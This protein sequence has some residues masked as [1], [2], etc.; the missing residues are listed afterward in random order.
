MS[1]TLRHRVKD[2]IVILAVRIG[3]SRPG[4]VYCLSLRIGSPFSFHR[5]LVTH[6]LTT[7]VP[8]NCSCLL[9]CKSLLATLLVL[10]K[11]T[12]VFC[13]GHNGTVRILQSEVH[14]ELCRH[15]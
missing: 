3:A 15:R 5:E 9:Q 2:T 12:F 14:G 13:C 10:V 4:A 6:V 7:P 11:D 1:T 8:L